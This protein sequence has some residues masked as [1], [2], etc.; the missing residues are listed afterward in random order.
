[1]IAA[2]SS[3]S[4][5]TL[6]PVTL[7]AIG[8]QP[9]VSILVGNYNYADY[10]RQTIESVLV[11]TYAK[12]ELIICDDGSTDQSIAVIESYLERDRRIRLLRKPNGGHASAL[13]AAFS[14]CRGDL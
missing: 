3:F 13:N 7:R 14:V 10:I 12:W 4:P 1:M 2:P 8:K 5:T 11:Q 6:E 9:L